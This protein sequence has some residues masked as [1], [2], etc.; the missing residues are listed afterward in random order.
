VPWRLPLVEQNCPRYSQGRQSSRL[1]FEEI[2][3]RDRIKAGRELERAG[4]RPALAALIAGILIVLR[5]ASN[6]K[7][8]SLPGARNS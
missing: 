5:N 6:S 1:I 4:T 7:S 2:D 3:D 8:L